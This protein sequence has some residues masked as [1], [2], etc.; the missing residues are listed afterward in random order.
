[1]FQY[2]LYDT[3]SSFVSFSPNR[4]YFH[5]MTH[6]SATTRM[7]KHFLSLCHYW[8]VRLPKCILPTIIY[9]L[10]WPK[11][12]TLLDPSPE[13]HATPPAVWVNNN[14]CLS[15][16]TQHMQSHPDFAL[17]NSTELLRSSDDSVNLGILKIQYALSAHCWRKKPVAVSTSLC[18]SHNFAPNVA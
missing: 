18:Q 6:S 12:S 15:E 16:V 2:A 10:S 5:W 7:N 11:S 17:Y 3:A 4:Y 8:F 13:I 1:M 9:L 14:F